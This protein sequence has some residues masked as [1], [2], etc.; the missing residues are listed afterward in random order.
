MK[1]N[2]FNLHLSLVCLWLFFF[3]FVAI[4]SS[5]NVKFVIIIKKP[6]TQTILV[7][8]CLDCTSEEYLSV[9]S[10]AGNTNPVTIAGGGGIR[11]WLGGCLAAS[12]GDR[13]QSH[14]QPLWR[15]C[16]IECSVFKWCTPSAL[17][18]CPC[19]HYYIRM[20]CPQAWNLA[21]MPSDSRNMA[22]L[23][24]SLHSDPRPS[25]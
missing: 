2:P 23:D 9:T 12:Q 14:P 4:S 11:K 25:L 19:P 18:N 10:H 13:P 22:P 16:R 5:V 21:S 7:T 8:F 17:S 15:D 24:L 3:F 1:K 20:Q 6:R